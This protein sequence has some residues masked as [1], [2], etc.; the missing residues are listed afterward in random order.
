MN[1]LRPIILI[2]RITNK[3]FPILEGLTYIILKKT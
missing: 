1:K 3:D 2:M